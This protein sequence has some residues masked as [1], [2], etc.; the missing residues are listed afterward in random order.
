MGGLGE[1]YDSEKKEMDELML[2]V[3]DDRVYVRLGKLFFLVC[4]WEDLV[5][6]WLVLEWDE[7]VVFGDGEVVWEGGLF[8]GGLGYDCG[9][10]LLGVG[11]CLLLGWGEFGWVF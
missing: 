7:M 1:L 2:M 5:W 3:F 11:G 9:F 6:D 4:I 8:G 10:C